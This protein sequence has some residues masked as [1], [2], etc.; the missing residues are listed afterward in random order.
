M[1]NLDKFISEVAGTVDKDRIYKD[2]L[3]R[4]AWGTDAGFYR[5][6]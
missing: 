4:L 2:E 1:M 5:W 3:R 6:I